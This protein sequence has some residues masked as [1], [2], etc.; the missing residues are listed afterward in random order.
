MSRPQ[1]S[2]YM[3]VMI[4]TYISLKSVCKLYVYGH[5][6]IAPSNDLSIPLLRTFNN[7]QRLTNMIANSIAPFE[8]W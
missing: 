8:T 1:Q 7:Q 6:V 5:I 2:S 4:I 3:V